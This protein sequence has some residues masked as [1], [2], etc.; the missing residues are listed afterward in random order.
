MSQL[1]VNYLEEKF[2]KLYIIP[3]LLVKS[4]MLDDVDTTGVYSASSGNSPVI[5]ILQCSIIT[6]TS[7]SGRPTGYLSLGQCY[8]HTHTHTH[9]RFTALLESVVRDEP[10][11]QVPER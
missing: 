8:W 3:G 1:V 2:N 7:P 5:L 10:G 6:T 9:N 11:E 4:G